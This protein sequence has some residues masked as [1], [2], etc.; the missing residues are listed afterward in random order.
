MRYNVDE[1]TR[2]LVNEE[3]A[4]PTGLLVRSREAARMLAIS[5]RKLWE[6]TNRKLIRAVRI[7]R[8]VRYDVRDLEAFI[9]AQ[10]KGS[11]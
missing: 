10:K 2:L 8:A 5:E 3:E 1:C 7:G 9:A 4:T 6:L 11:Q